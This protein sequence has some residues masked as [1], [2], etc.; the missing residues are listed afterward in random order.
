LSTANLLD[1]AM[2][3]G[4]FQEFLVADFSQF[5]DGIRMLR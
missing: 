4:V 3:L 5:A 1:A 2:S